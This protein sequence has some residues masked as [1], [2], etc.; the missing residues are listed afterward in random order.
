[1]LAPFPG[2]R[3]AGCEYVSFELDQLSGRYL[4]YD[5]LMAEE[6]GCRSTF[7]P[8]GLLLPHQ[9]LFQNI[10]FFKIRMSLTAVAGCA[11]LVSCKSFLL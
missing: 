10:I 9:T 1:M 6:V 2:C 4:I 11:V 7:A 5:T 3:L 8:R